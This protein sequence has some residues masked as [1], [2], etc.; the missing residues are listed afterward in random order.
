MQATAPDFTR[1]ISSQFTNWHGNYGTLTP[2]RH[3]VRAKIRLRRAECAQRHVEW[4][5]Q[6]RQ[7]PEPRPRQ[8]PLWRSAAPSPPLHRRFGIRGSRPI[9]QARTHPDPGGDGARFR[10]EHLP[11]MRVTCKDKRTTVANHVVEHVLVRR[12]YANP[13]PRPT[14]GGS[15]NRFGE[16][17]RSACEGRR[18]RRV[19][20]PTAH[21]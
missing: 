4:P 19:Q 7:I 1:D 5:T 17:V 21:R 3:D 13:H 15:R 9:K 18:R 2:H 6:P 10:L 12:R 20:I 8:L 11:S 16:A 14:F